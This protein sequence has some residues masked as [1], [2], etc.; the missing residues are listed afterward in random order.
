MWS[1]DGDELFYRGAEGLMRVE[2]STE[3]AFET[4]TPELM[5]PMDE[6][7][8]TFAPGRSYDVS[9]DGERFLVV[10]SVPAPTKTPLVVVQN[11]LSARVGSRD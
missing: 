5:F 11:W 1:P 8:F 9:S 4:G 10:Q 7:L 3:P 6:T 2:V